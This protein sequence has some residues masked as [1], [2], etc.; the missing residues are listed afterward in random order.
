MSR[1]V[2]ETSIRGWVLACAAAELVGM[3]AAASAAKGVQA[4]TDRPG[5]LGSTAVALALVV[6]GGLVEGVALGTAQ[7]TLLSQRWPALRRGAFVAV[8]V[9]A[10]GL[11]WAAGSAPGVLSGDDTGTEPPLALMLAG[12]AGIGL[13]MG[14]LLGAAQAWVLRGAVPHAWRWVAANAVAWPPVMM[15]IFFGASRPESDWSVPAVVGIGALTGAVAGAVLGGL[16]GLWLSSLDGQPVHNRVVLALVESQRFGMERGMVGLAVRGR[17]SGIVRRFPAQY[18]EDGAGLVVVPGKPERKRWWRNLQAV[19]SPV[20]ALVEGEWQSATAYLLRP[21]DA[22][23]EVALATYRARWP[24]TPVADGQPVVRLV[25]AEHPAR[26]PGGLS[27][28]SG[29]RATT[30]GPG[31]AESARSGTGAIAKRRLVGPCNRN[32]DESR[33]VD[34]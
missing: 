4:L 10:A 21:G 33:S 26:T 1:L 8:T 31:P 13:M 6:A 9:V 18:A 14:P 24:R 2:G 25:A 20:E 27:P 34:P 23:Y 32:E 19:G 22:G 29:R 16:T 28:R 3:T 17:R 7:G 30:P 15:V 5:L 11:G 12:A